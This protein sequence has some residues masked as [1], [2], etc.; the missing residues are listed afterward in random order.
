MLSAASSIQS[1]AQPPR[2]K[3]LTHGD[4]RR[5]RLRV[6][7]A[8]GSL[9]PLRS[10]VL[11]AAGELFECPSAWAA[12]EA[13]A[14]DDQLAPRFACAPESEHYLR[15][16]PDGRRVPLEHEE[17]VRQAIGKLAREGRL[18]AHPGM[19]R[20]AIVRVIAAAASAD[21]G[22]GGRAST[23]AIAFLAD[24]SVRHTR[25]VLKYG[26]TIGIVDRIRCD[27]ASDWAGAP[28]AA[29]RDRRGIWIVGLVPRAMAQDMSD[30]DLLDLAAMGD[31][32]E[33]RRR[34]RSSW[35]Q[36]PLTAGKAEAPPPQ[37]PPAVPAS[38]PSAA[39]R[40]P[41]PAFRAASL[42]ALRPELATLPKLLEELARV[43]RRGIFLD[44]L[45]VAMMGTASP[46]DGAG[47]PAEM[48]LRT[49]E[50]MIAK[51][52]SGKTYA[53][54]DAPWAWTRAMLRKRL[55]HFFLQKSKDLDAQRA[56][57]GQK[58]EQRRANEE[59]ATGMREAAER[60]DADAR[61][62]DEPIGDDEVLADDV[63]QDADDGELDAL[64]FLT[65]TVPLAEVPAPCLVL[66]STGD[67]VFDRAAGETRA[68]FAVSFDHSFALVQFDG[69]ADGVLS[70]RFVNAFA[71]NFIED[72]FLPTLTAKIA[73][74]VGR[75]VTV[76]S[77]IDRN[78]CRPLVRR[79][80]EADERGPPA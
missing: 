62:G 53:T 42:E 75:P 22:A 36:A 6:E 41:V 35:T 11:H 3:A 77:S 43:T 79:A 37:T 78:L 19:T 38:L 23:A 14:Q 48:V 80:E 18:P 44:P 4:F 49:V 17:Q 10:E 72:K 57:A 54:A 67:A 64:Q 46:P 24:L 63:D 47:L 52:S 55:R 56:E 12:A 31:R 51:I 30:D 60:R 33:P 34:S 9:R 5:R 28:L 45:D 16:L 61:D 15:Q 8:S 65:P 70:L 68:L 27:R 29:Y 66:A 32:V 39:P 1:E 59:L 7:S 76:Q 20:N 58:A 2:A 21:D 50:E 26:M 25:D 13:A 73:E 71:S 40:D 69:L 74:Q